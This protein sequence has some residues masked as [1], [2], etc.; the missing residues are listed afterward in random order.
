[1]SFVP[2]DLRAAYCELHKI[3]MKIRNYKD[4]RIWQK[5]MEITDLIYKITDKFPKNEL[6]S[7]TDQMR[8]AAISIPSNIAEGFPRHSKKEYKHFLSIALGS[9]TELETQIVIAKGRDYI[10]K[11]D[12]SNIEELIDHERRMIINLLKLF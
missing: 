8:R 7:L 12:L 5:G 1:M 3:D 2:Y 11:D 10:I 4:L 9:C 6:F